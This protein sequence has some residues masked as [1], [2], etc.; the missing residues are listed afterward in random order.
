MHF[1]KSIQATL[2]CLFLISNSIAQRYN[3]NSYGIANG[4]PNN[5]INKII[6]DKTGM[7]WIGTMSGACRFDGKSFIRFDQSNSLS[8]NPVKTMFQDSKGNI[9]IGTIRKGFL[10]IQRHRIQILYHRTRFAQ[11]YCECNLRRH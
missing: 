7:L 2:L 11:R 8:N 5:Q 9:W 1:I 3:Y 10:Q 6:Q 4:L